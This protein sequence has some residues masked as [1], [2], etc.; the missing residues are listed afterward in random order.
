MA[1]WHHHATLDIRLGR[2]EPMVGP[3][4][5]LTVF[6]VALALMRFLLRPAESDPAVCWACGQRGQHKLWCP[7]R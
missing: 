6:I 1:D 7:N 2:G 3:I 5:A 4:V